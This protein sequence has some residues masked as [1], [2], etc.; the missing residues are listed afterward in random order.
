VID[1][2]NEFDDAL[3]GPPPDTTQ[4]PQPAN[5]LDQAT[6]WVAA[7]ARIRRQRQQYIEAHNAAIARL[8][9]RLQQHLQT[10]QQQE[11]WYTEALEMYHRMILANDPD[12]KT[13]HTPAGTL[14]SVATQPVWEI[15]DEQA[16][17]AWAA[18]HLPETL[19]Q[20]PQ[21]PPKPSKTE[22]KKTLKTIANQA[23]QN[24]TGKTRLTYNGQTIPGLT[25]TPATRK[26]TI[27]T[28]Q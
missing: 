21:P 2:E 1:I 8:D 4:P 20:P 14:K 12:A 26:F 24:T 18:Q 13:I 10:L 19:I 23:L 16:Y 6:Q 5:S 7:I 28:D 17:T 27:I 15:D 25:V 3:A 11:N 9:Q 22:I